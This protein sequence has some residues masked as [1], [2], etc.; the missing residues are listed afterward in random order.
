[1][2]DN[3]SRNGMNSTTP[4]SAVKAMKDGATS[5]NASHKNEMR[6]PIG[7][8]QMHMN[9]IIKEEED[10]NKDPLE[11]RFRKI[12]NLKVSFTLLF[13]CFLTFFIE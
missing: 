8:A 11:F 3:E 7:Q 6:I 10:K 9:D 4:N 13:N 2:S 1:M 5:S 12:H